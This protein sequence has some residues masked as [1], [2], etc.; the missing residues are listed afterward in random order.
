MD[1]L[2]CFFSFVYEQLCFNAFFSFF[3][4]NTFVS[5]RFFFLYNRLLYRVTRLLYYNSTEMSSVKYHLTE[6]RCIYIDSYKMLMRSLN[7]ICHLHLLINMIL[8]LLGCMCSYVYLSFCLSVCMRIFVL[9]TCVCVSVCL[10]VCII[11]PW[12]V[13]RALAT[14]IGLKERDCTVGFPTN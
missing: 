8:C 2:P 5:T 9:C 7:Y 10:D 11:C 1:F 3:H 6:T 12:C 4:V 14:I 13:T